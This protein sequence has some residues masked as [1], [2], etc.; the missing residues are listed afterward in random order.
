[1]AL[2]LRARDIGFK[3]LNAFHRSA[4]RLSGGRVGARALGMAMVELHVPGRVSGIP[5]VT[6]LASP[7]IDED[8]TVLLVASKGGD[9]RDP[10]WFKNLVAHPEVDLVVAGE[11]GSYLAR[12]LSPEEAEA[13][14]EAIVSAYGPY[15]AYRAKAGRPIPVVACRPLRGT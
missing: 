1:M 4:L 6:I 12:V 13:R 10:E 14:W 9:S 2:S 11:R 8:G 5:R 15:D 3:A 7:V